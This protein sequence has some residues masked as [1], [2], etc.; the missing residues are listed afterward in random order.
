[1]GKILKTVFGKSG[2]LSNAIDLVKVPQIIEQ[3]KKEVSNVKE[4]LQQVDKELAKIC[5]E[6]VSD[7]QVNLHID[8]TH[9]ERELADIEACLSKMLQA[10]HEYADVFGICVNETLDNQIM[11]Y[12]KQI[13]EYQLEMHKIKTEYEQHVN[14]L[15]MKRQQLQ[16][17]KS[18][19]EEQLKIAKDKLFKLQEKKERKKEQFD[20]NL[21]RIF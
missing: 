8:F 14:E 10:K 17:E 3:S 11:S 18:E 21:G 7:T 4:R 15:V 2:V 16:E 20:K 12:Q 9:K 6:N 19:L 5:E 1:M 13:M